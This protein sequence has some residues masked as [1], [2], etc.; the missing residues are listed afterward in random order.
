[1]SDDPTAAMQE[2]A[3]PAAEHERLTAFAGTFKAEVKI[4][5]GPG[6]PMISTGSMTNSW[7]LGGRFLRQDY[8]GDPSPGP[9]PFPNFE[10][11]GYWGF[12]KNTQ[13]YEGFWIDTASTIMQNETGTVDESGKVWTMTGEIVGPDGEVSIKRSVLTLIDD[14]HHRM[15]MFFTKGDQDFK[16]ME[17]QYARA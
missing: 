13:R 2:M 16:G 15:E 5:M 6:D 7:V 3:A 17:I 9:D 14:D 11:H 10:G 8:K 1:M 4:W 12:N